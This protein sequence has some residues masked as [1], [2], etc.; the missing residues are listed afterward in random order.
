MSERMPRVTA[1]QI[2]KLLEKTGFVLSRQNGSHMIYK[3]DAGLR[4]TDPF[5]GAKILHLK[6]LKS[7]MREA[8]LTV[9]KLTE[10]LK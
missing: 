10:L 2:T 4:A 5:H 6:I 3:N 7:I 9:E 8:Y 1:T